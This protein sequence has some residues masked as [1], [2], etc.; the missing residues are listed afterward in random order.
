MREEIANLV[1]PVLTQGLRLKERLTSSDPPDFRSAQK[2][3][4]GMLLAD[5]RAARYPDFG[6]EA[7]P[8]PGGGRAGDRFLGIRYA[9]VCWLDEVMIADTPWKEEWTENKMEQA[10][11]ESNDRAWQ[12]WEQADRA[13]REGRTDALEAFFLCAMLGFRGDKQADEVR[14]KLKEFQDQIDAGQEREWT[15]PV[16]GQPKSFVPPLQGEQR[17]QK[18]LFY[19]IVSLLLLIPVGMFSLVFFMGR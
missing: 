8:A 5:A 18:M 3:L 7:A 17:K 16:G 1:F 12:F 15:G 2:E 6:G 19:A 4:Q 10:L 14:D 13:A 11:Y 9:L